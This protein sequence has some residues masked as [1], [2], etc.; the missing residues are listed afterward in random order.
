LSIQDQGRG[1]SADQQAA[2]F[3]PFTRFKENASRNPTGTGL[4]LAFV[5]TV[6][7]RHHGSITV[8][9]KEDAGSTFSL[10][11]PRVI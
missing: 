1:I 6:V 8:Q 4:G 3:R 9:S 5:I 7:N 2:L 11:L 10:R